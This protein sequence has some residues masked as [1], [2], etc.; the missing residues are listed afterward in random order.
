VEFLPLAPADYGRQ[1]F[2]LREASSDLLCREVDLVVE[3]A[4]PGTVEAVRPGAGVIAN[5][6]SG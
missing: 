2:A 6:F 4:I 1:Y 3:R 5:A